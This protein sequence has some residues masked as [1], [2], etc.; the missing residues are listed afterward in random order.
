MMTLAPKLLFGH[1]RLEPRTVCLAGSLQGFQGKLNW[2]L[3]RG[4]FHQRKDICEVTQV[5]TSNMIPFRLLV[6]L[7]TNYANI[8]VF[9]NATA[10]NTWKWN[11]S[12]IDCMY[13]REKNNSWGANFVNYDFSTHLRCSTQHLGGFFWHQK[14]FCFLGFDL[15]LPP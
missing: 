13:L 6:Y 15:L 2:H 14:K 9:I 5:H 11:P 4:A 3:H 1:V 8:M 12:R 7:K 10:W